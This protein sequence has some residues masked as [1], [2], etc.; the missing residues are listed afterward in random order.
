MTDYLATAI[1]PNETRV[2]LIESQDNVINSKI[3]AEIHLHLPYRIPRKD[4]EISNIAA[5]E[6]LSKLQAISERQAQIEEFL[7]STGPCRFSDSTKS[8]FANFNS[9]GV[10]AYFMGNIYTRDLKIITGLKLVFG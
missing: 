8:G 2:T 7:N 10:W 4:L 1:L 3:I 5:L 9:K 6:G